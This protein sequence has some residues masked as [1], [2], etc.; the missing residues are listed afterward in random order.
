M[1]NDSKYYANLIFSQT[2]DCSPEMIERILIEYR[3]LLIKSNTYQ[4]VEVRSVVPLSDELK[5]GILA[6]IKAP[7]NAVV[8]EIIDQNIIGGFIAT[9]NDV[10]LDMSLRNKLNMLKES[11]I[12]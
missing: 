1:T 3:T 11:L 6:K 5:K 12:S 2:K 9:Y 8:K 4:E 10:L 7:E